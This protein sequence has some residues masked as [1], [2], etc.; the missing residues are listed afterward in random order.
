MLGKTH[1]AVGV[2]ASMA[3]LHP[4]TLSELLVGI[5]A[6][7]VGAIISDIDV[8]T[9]ESHRDA[10]IITMMTIAA[11]VLVIGFDKL[12]DIGVYQM[13]SQRT[14]F[15]RI[16]I[17]VI[18]F[19]GVCAFGKEQPHRSFMHSI[20]AL[21]ILSALTGVIFPMAMPYFAVAFLSHLLTDLFNF[22]RVHLLYPM[23]GGI[24]FKMFHATGIANNV[25]FIGGCLIFGVELLV[26]L[27][28]IIIK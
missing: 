15:V 23:P 11:I 16:I 12:F 28:H 8:G 9:T 19:V 27:L 4:T 5:G 1:L 6:A 22:K 10:D 25:L 18:T 24:C 17:G 20:M 13:L 21:A 7:S 3:V 2:A 26:N 14:N